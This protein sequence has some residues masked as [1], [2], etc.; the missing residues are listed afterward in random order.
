MVESTLG[1]L[2]SRCDCRM[3][4]NP[5][6]AEETATF[7]IPDLEKSP[8]SSKTFTTLTQLRAPNMLPSRLYRNLGIPPAMRSLL[9]PHPSLPATV[10][11][12]LRMRLGVLP[13]TVG[14][15]SRQF[16][17]SVPTYDLPTTS[18]ATESVEE[19][20][21]ANVPK[22]QITF[23][24]T[25]NDCNHR[26]THQFTKQAYEKGIVLIQCPGCK[27]RCVSELNHIHG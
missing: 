23:T 18:T 17:S 21:R 26:S 1:C 16:S 22:Y 25:A 10:S 14:A 13:G 20:S 12:Q 5:A 11:I 19:N 24:C 9:K 27:N 2:N 6:E 7:C 8:P 3:V 4:W 15:G